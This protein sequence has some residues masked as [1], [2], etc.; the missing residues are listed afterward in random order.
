MRNPAQPSKEGHSVKV[1]VG[2]GWIE[3]ARKIVSPNY[4]ER[5]PDAMVDLVVIHGISLPKGVFGTPWVEA[6]FTNTLDYDADASFRELVDVNVSAHLLIRRKGELLQFVSLN[7]RA[8]HAGVSQ[9]QGRS[10]CNDFSIGIEIE[11][12]DDQPYTA[13]QYLQLARLANVLMETYPAIR[14]ERI[15]GHCDIAPGRKT[16]PGPAFDWTRFH[17]MLRVAGQSALQEHAS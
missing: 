14:G 11:G 1:D 13:H 5:P 2:T 15:V 4:D 7:K 10:R 6:L 9:W 17:A 12:C 3:G 16:D 8:W